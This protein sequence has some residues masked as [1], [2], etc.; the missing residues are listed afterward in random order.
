M[1][2]IL[3]EK[4]TGKSFVSKAVLYDLLQTKHYGACWLHCSES[5][6]SIQS[7]LRGS[8]AGTKPCDTWKS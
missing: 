6:F 2:K 7:L 1:P 4:T 3:V 5:C 8:S